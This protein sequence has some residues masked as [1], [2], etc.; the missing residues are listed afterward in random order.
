MQQAKRVLSNLKFYNSVAIKQDSNSNSNSNLNKLI[1]S[2]INNADLK[3][4]LMKSI[5]DIL[6]YNTNIEQISDDGLIRKYTK[7][8]NK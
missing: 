1:I 2:S 4:F 7:V 5:Y 6:E 8:I 3:T